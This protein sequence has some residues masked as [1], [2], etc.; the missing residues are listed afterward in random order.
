VIINRDIEDTL[1]YTMISQLKEFIQQQDYLNF[2]ARFLNLRINSP[3]VHA[4]GGVNFKPAIAFSKLETR[5][6]SFTRFSK[7]RRTECAY[8]S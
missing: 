3:D 2:K 8:S 5:E 7:M 1:A 6:L 4:Y